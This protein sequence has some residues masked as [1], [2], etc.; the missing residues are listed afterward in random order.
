MSHFQNKIEIT[1]YLWETSDFPTRVRARKAPERWFYVQQ[2][3][4]DRQ[5]TQLTLKYLLTAAIQYNFIGLINTQC[6]CNLLVTVR[7]LSSN[8][9]SVR[10]PFSQVQRVLIVEHFLASRSYLTC[11]NEF[12]VIFPDSPVPNK[13]TISP[14]TNS[15]APEPEGSSPHS[16]QP[17]NDPYP[18]PGES[19]PHTPNQ[20]S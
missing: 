1:S 3:Q 2:V 9:P 19:T 12:R 6:R 16:Q 14:V 10:T 18:E 17:A 4:D 5:V 11:Q 20:S 8:G 13:P 7:L 15:V